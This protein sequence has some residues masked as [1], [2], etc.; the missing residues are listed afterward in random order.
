MNQH[1]KTAKR[2]P[3][4]R[5]II[6]LS[7]WLMTV[8]LAFSFLSYL[9]T[10]KDDQS[11]V[12]DGGVGRTHNIVG[13]FG[14]YLSHHSFYNGFGLSAFCLVFLLFIW[15]YRFLSRGHLRLRKVTFN[16]C[17]LM[18]YGS[19]ISAYLLPSAYKD[20]FPFSGAVGEALSNSLRHI[21]GNIG[22]FIVLF[23]FFPI[24]FFGLA[25]GLRFSKRK[26]KASRPLQARDDL[27]AI[28]NLVLPS[29]QAEESRAKP[30]EA[31]QVSVSPN[32]APHNV[33][34]QFNNNVF[35]ATL[36]RE[37]IPMPEENSKTIEPPK[38]SFEIIQKEPV[39]EVPM[40]IEEAKGTTVVLP[41]QSE[42]LHSLQREVKPVIVSKAMEPNTLNVQNLSSQGLNSQDN[43]ASIKRVQEITPSEGK[44][45]AQS[46]PPAREGV[47]VRATV[48]NFAKTTVAGPPIS[49][50]VDR[51]TAT[52]SGSPVNTLQSKPS[53][54]QDSASL[55]PSSSSG[56]Q[57]AGL[58]QTPELTA[59]P[60]LVATGEAYDPRADLS[61][62]AF[63]SKD[64]LREYP[65][66]TH[67]LSPFEVTQ[68]EQR[69]ASLLK[70]FDIKFSTV[71]ATVGPAVTLYE[72]A[73]ELTENLRKIENR[74]PNLAMALEAMSVRIMIP[75]PGKSVVGIEVPNK[76]QS[77]VG[78]RNLLFSGTFQ[79]GQAVLPIGLG[80]TIDNMPFILDLAEM[81]H[82]LIAGATKQGKSVGIN[83]I[84]LSL[85]YKQHP[86]EL[87]LVLIDPKQVELGIYE[88]I[89]RHYLAKI[90]S[91]EQ[92]VIKDSKK[93]VYALQAL[94]LEMEHRLSLMSLARVRDIA[95]YNAK[96]RA[97]Q[98]NPQEGHKFLPFIVV[99]V[100][101]YADLVMTEKGIEKPLIML[102]Q[103]AR[104]A[105]I[106]LIVATQ[107]PSADVLV[108]MIKANCP[109]RLA[110]RV[111]QA[112]DSRIILDENGA[113]S[114][115]GRGDML[116]K[117]GDVGGVK[118]VQCAFVST[119]EVDAVVNF[120]NKQ[121][122][123]TSAYELPEYSNEEEEDLSQEATSQGTVKRDTL[124]V[125]IARAVV[126]DQRVSASSLQARYSIGQPR[127]T[128]IVLQL[129]RAGIIGPLRS[130]K[131]EVLMSD[132]EL[133][134]YLDQQN[135]L[136]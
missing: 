111:A 16:I 74:A 94:V 126:R 41:S 115:I 25:F 51:Q 96:F 26:P 89:E 131:R 86:A 84:L 35:D 54:N 18:F 52:S 62:Y 104:A 105:G 4:G 36:A 28:E 119:E 128:R 71:R 7:L 118:R 136:S 87:K 93:A 91:E 31:E 45:S 112:T 23:I 15:G 121:Q 37:P 56:V 19:I 61:F 60:V 132:L 120:I 68:N 55:F 1:L 17:F 108:G 85:L 8:L 123:Y 10:W 114:L 124:F 107:R 127:A 72:V 9:F 79:H 40:P 73:T 49:K 70:K 13:F 11:L 116:V 100:D 63:P 38:S 97:R 88:L 42:N 22:A 130:G 106:H 92:A 29:F 110:F 47:Y 43:S 102:A 133:E 80:R 65:E 134:Y 109:G 46:I 53:Q 6:G 122:A 57:R 101:E 77:V 135:N 99:V 32:D 98:L 66:N 125:D 48:N 50:P 95:G 82:L 21:I 75:V 34:P 76:K 64:L 59:S 30:I 103:K 20:A 69:I 24:M 44:A 81:P 113:E 12:L 3:K 14:A 5:R 129:E 67:L 90:P 78:L 117:T 27:S 33:V 83:T 39:L 2:L 58:A